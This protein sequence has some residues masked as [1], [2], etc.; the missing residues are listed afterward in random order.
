MIVRGIAAVLYAVSILWFC[1][2]FYWIRSAVFEMGGTVGDF[3]CFANPFFFIFFCWYAVVFGLA[4]LVMRPNLV[5]GLVF[6]GFILL[7]PILYG[8]CALV[9][10]EPRPLMP[11]M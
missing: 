11:Y 9:T 3:V 8:G 1:I 5:R 4:S 6:V 2:Y 10:G 7:E